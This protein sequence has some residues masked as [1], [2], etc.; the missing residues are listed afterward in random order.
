MITGLPT[1]AQ[2]NMNADANPGETITT[3]FIG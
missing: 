1:N 2:V 3:S